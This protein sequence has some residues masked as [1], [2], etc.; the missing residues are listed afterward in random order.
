[1]ING[2]FFS[3][4]EPNRNVPYWRVNNRTEPNFFCIVSALLL[5]VDV[6]NFKSHSLLYHILLSCLSVAVHNFRPHSFSLTKF[7][8]PQLVIY[9]INFVPHCNTLRELLSQRELHNF[10]PL[11]YKRSVINWYVDK[12]K[13]H[14]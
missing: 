10:V 8:T 2:P 11:C 7:R 1:M 14:I 12:F 4:T 5:I 13:C 6:S 9:N 3:Y